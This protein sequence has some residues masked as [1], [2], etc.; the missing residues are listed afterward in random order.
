MKK[1]ELQ[2]LEIKRLKDIEKTPNKHGKP[3]THTKKK[4]G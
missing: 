3:S 4:K 1:Q 2:K